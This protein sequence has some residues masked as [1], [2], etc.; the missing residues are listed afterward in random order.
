VVVNGDIAEATT[1]FLFSL[2]GVDEDGSFVKIPNNLPICQPSLEEINF[3][4]QVRD[5]C[6]G[7]QTRSGKR[8]SQQYVGNCPITR[9]FEGGISRL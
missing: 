2:P 7:I 3:N 5:N 4:T 1:Q 9:V 6:W 8:Q